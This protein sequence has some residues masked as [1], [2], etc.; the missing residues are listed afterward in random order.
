LVFCISWLARK[1]VKKELIRI[2]FK[3]DQERYLI[4]LAFALI[5]SLVF[6]I[7]R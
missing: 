2:S 5:L 4:G 6:S 3:T 7:S 1:A